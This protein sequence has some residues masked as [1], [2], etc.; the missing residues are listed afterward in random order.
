MLFFLVHLQSDPSGA[1]G[2]E[3]CHLR[4]FGLS[5][6]TCVCVCVSDCVMMMIMMVNVELLKV[7]RW[8]LSVGVSLVRTTFQALGDHLGFEN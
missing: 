2:S 1:P 4:M 7:Q 8:L 6:T 5:D 3:C